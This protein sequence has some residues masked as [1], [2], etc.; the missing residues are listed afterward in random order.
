MILKHSHV[1]IT[2]G[3]SGIGLAIARRAAVRGARLTLVARDAAKLEAAR[4]ALEREVPGC[5]AAVRAADVANRAQLEAALADAGP[6]D[7]LVTSAGVARPG[8]FSELAPEVFEEAIA[9]NYLGTVNAVRAVLPAMR[10]RKAGSILMI[11]S[12]AGLT[13]IFGYSAYSP[14]KFAVRGF[15]EVLRAE[16]RPDGVTVTLVH[17]PDTETPQLVSEN[18]TKPAETRAITASGGIWTADAV[19]A[20]ALDAALA[21]RFEAAPGLPLTLLLRLGSVVA[22]LLRWSFDRKAR[23]ARG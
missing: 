17:P 6:V 10:S 3:S 13:G 8:Y 18:R 19:A 14:S 9:V 21:G 7:L 12:G 16:V 15:A 4:S 23:R 2:G 22:P 5:V 11:G 1:V 20:V